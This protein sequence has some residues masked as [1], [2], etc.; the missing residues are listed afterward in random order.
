VQ[1]DKKLLADKE[2]SSMHIKLNIIEKYNVEV[3]MR[4]G[5]ILRGNIFRPEAKGKFPGLLMRTPYGNYKYDLDNVDNLPINIACAVRAGYV[6][7]IQDTRGR[8]TSD[9]K[10]IVNYIENTGDAEDG[11][12]TVEW[13]SEQDYCNGKIGTFGIS[14]NS[15]MQ[16][17]LAKLSPPHL[18]AMCA[19]SM[20][21]KMAGI[22]W[23]N[24]IFRMGR[25]IHWL[26]NA[27]APDIRKRQGMSKPHTPEEALEMWDDFG[28]ERWFNFMP[29]IDL[30]KYLPKG[31]A[32]YVKEWFKNPNS[33]SWGP[34]QDTYKGIEVPNLDIS[35]Y[36]DHCM[37]TMK[38]LNGMQK[39]A[40]NEIA[41]TQTKLIIG[42]WNHRYLGYRKIGD[43]DFGPL[44]ELNKHDLIIRWF[45]YWLK[46]FNNGIKKEPTVSY[47]VMGSGRWKAANTWPPKGTKKLVYY[48]KSKGVANKVKNSGLLSQTIHKDS[49]YDAYSYDPKNPTPT[50]W[51][52]EF[53]TVP[54]DRNLLNYRQDILRYCTDP[55]KDS[56][57][58]VGY[59]EV[60]LYASSSALDTDFFVRLADENQD[61]VALE[62]C[63]GVVRARYRNSLNQEELLKP[64]QIIEFKI[65]LGPTACHFAKG[66]RIRLEIQSSDF[67]N[68]DR[69]HNTGKNDL[70]DTELVVANQKIYHSPDYPSQL[71]LELNSAK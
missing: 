1:K 2:K 9:G 70:F 41:R 47:F 27:I 65:K 4:D 18:K 28:L 51:T 46:D 66:H 62:I 52:K 48:I 39:N 55:L 26:M 20:P 25:R 3:P 34:A 10:Y 13:L 6:V 54:S 49:N 71:I 33:R 29:W 67:P 11:Y 24:G 32:E 31:L 17:Q 58:V 56:I 21:I 43:I 12:D 35:G 57:E 7:M 59:P 68:F 50:L 8:Y 63:F 30:P 36:Y 37:E 23:T 53:F 14:Y 69:N 16:W 38:N 44:A 60:I 15:W 64:G 61:G 19:F 5:A 22:D 45:D 42:P 40:R